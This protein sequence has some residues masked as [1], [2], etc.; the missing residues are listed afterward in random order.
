MK[1]FYNKVRNSEF[2]VIGRVSLITLVI[3]LTHEFSQFFEASFIETF[4]ALILLGIISYLVWVVLGFIIVIL[5][6]TVGWVFNL[7]NIPPKL[8]EHIMEF[9]YY[10]SSVTGIDYTCLGENK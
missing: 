4:V 3:L 7:R 6:E 9:F 1:E 8:D 10:K 5:L 2:N